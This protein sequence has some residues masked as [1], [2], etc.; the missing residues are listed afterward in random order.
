MLATAY[1][2]L[3]VGSTFFILVAFPLFFRSA[4]LQPVN[5]LI[6][7]VKQVEHHD[8]TVVVPVRFNDEAEFSG[9]SSEINP[10]PFHL[11]TNQLQT[12]PLC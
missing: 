5:A 7:G 6:A 12:Q 8:L 1:P 2:Q 9:A 3:T 10:T 11:L 4:L